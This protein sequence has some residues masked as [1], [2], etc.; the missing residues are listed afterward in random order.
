M[1]HGGSK[2]LPPMHLKGARKYQKTANFYGFFVACPNWIG[3]T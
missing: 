2:S 1:L 3:Y